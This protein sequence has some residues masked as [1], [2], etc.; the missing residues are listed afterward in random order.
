MVCK[1]FVLIPLFA[2]FW[3]LD[4]GSH[5]E[6]HL[7]RIGLAPYLT[8]VGGNLEPH[9][10]RLDPYLT[11]A[12]N[13][14]QEAAERVKP[15]IASAQQKFQ[16]QV[17]RL[18]PLKTKA[19]QVYTK[20]LQPLQKRVL[21]AYDQHIKPHKKYVLLLSLVVFLMLGL[22]LVLRRRCQP[23]PNSTAEVKMPQ[24]AVTTAAAEESSRTEVQQKQTAP[25][26]GVRQ[27]RTSSVGPRARKEEDLLLKILN[28]ATL[29]ELTKVAGI[30]R[31]SAEKIVKAREQGTI[32][33]LQEAGLSQA[34]QTR[35]IAGLQNA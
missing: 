13:A 33:S 7:Q 2:S 21:K 4:V 35:I 12:S 9:L 18:Q 17:Q 16:V 31:V 25:I 3:T 15:Y 28:F 24:Q 1:A 6:P 19:L 23:V 27:R 29:Q 32:K 30:G 26:A 34:V 14:T 20:H 5:L 22:V 10:K 11:K 8:K